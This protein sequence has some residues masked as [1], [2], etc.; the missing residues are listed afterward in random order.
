MSIYLINPKI[1]ELDTLNIC[2]ILTIF[3]YRLDKCSKKLVLSYSY[4]FVIGSL[5]KMLK[6]II[7]VFCHIC[8]MLQFWWNS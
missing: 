1:M 2:Q 5:K 7:N 8:L 4:S 3:L 6:I